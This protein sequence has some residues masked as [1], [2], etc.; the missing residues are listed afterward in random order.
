MSKHVAVLM[1]GLSAEREV[2]FAGGR[3]AVEALE[4]R[5][6]QVTPIDVDRTLCQQLA[7]AKPDV[8]YNALHGP[9]GE[10]GTVQGMLEILGHSLQPFRRACLGPCHGQGHGQEGFCRCRHPLP[11]KRDDHHRSAARERADGPALCGQAKP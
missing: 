10:D 6:Y 8:V 3:P 4:A 11:K 1:G 2:S 7:K 9:F 5:G